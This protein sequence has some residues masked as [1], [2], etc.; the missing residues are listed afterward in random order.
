M[1][2]SLGRQSALG[3]GVRMSWCCGLVI[4]NFRSSQLIHYLKSHMNVTSSDGIVM[5]RPELAAQA[6][7]VDSLE[8]MPG[9]LFLRFKANMAG[10]R[11]PPCPCVGVRRKDGRVVRFDGE[12][13]V[14]P[15]QGGGVPPEV[16]DVDALV[17]C[18]S[19]VSLYDVPKS[20]VPVCRQ[21]APFARVSISPP[22]ELPARR[23][24]D[25]SYVNACLAGEG[26]NNVDEELCDEE[27]AC[28]VDTK[29]DLDLGAVE[30]HLP[31]D[32]GYD[33]C[34]GGDSSQQLAKAT[35]V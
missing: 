29:E 18:C 27:V 15:S 35:V 4:D 24:I 8:V 14:Y 10:G 3:I 9:G 19:K 25:H 1:V 11:Q 28:L 33:V 31:G 5:L 23:H 2:I 21:P 22:P 26:M 16:Q 7:E 32:E 17:A 6:M 12:M 34:C 30:E 20:V 13:D